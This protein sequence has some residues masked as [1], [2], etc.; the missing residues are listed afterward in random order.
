MANVRGIVI[1]V[2]A[3]LPLTGSLDQQI[4]A[5]TAVKEANASG[6][7]LDLFKSAGIVIDEVKAEEKTRRV[8]AT[9]AAPATEGNADNAGTSEASA[10]ASSAD[11]SGLK[12]AFDAVEPAGDIDAVE[13]AGTVG[14]AQIE[15]DD[16]TVVVPQFLRSAATAGE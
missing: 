16:D 12:A 14:G 6:N 9:E 4:E 3:F 1:S 8:A 7:Y 10:S 15:G 11:Q 2:K 13:P 5:L